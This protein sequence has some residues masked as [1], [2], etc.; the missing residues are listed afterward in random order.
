MW[1]IS[2]SVKLNI[3]RIWSS[4]LCGPNRTQSIDTG[5]AQWIETC[6]KYL[7]IDLCDVGFGSICDSSWNLQD[8]HFV[9]LKSSLNE[10]GI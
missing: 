8:K 5:S 7:I 2:L 4:G 9:R 1:S 10:I 6:S 3:F